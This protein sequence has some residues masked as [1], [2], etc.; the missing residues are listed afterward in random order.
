MLK[1]VKGFEKSYSPQRQAPSRL[2]EPLKAVMEPEAVKPRALC[3]TWFPTH[4]TV[5]GEMFLSE[6]E[7][8]P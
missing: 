3:R 2:R 7:E 1:S 5:I 4:I 8:I 6:N